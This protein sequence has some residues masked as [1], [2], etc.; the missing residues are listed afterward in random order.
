MQITQQNMALF[1]AVTLRHQH[2]KLGNTRVRGDLTSSVIR[3]LILFLL[4]PHI[5]SNEVTVLPKF[6]RIVSYGDGFILQN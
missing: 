1:S 2:E 5:S 3:E 4:L 6:I